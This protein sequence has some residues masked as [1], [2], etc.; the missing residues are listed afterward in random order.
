[1]HFQILLCKAT[2]VFWFFFYRFT[3]EFSL[4][5]ATNNFKEVSKIVSDND[6]KLVYTSSSP[7]S[8][9]LLAIKLKKKFGLKW[10]ADLRDPFTDGYMWRFPT[11]LHWLLMRWREKRWL[12]QADKI[13]VNTPEVEKLYHKRNIVSPDKITHITNGY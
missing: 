9:W 11:K 2:D 4:W 7:Y 3:W 8:S 1:M 10:V 6:I 12:A 5:W 13:I